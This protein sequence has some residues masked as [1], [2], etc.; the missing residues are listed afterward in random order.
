MGK[1]EGAKWLP[2]KP[3]RG[4]IA[5]NIGDL[6]SHWSDGELYANLHRVRMPRDEEE[7]YKS[8]Y[9]IAYFIQP[10]SSYVIEPK[11]NDPATAGEFMEMWLKASFK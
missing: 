7:C 5:V 4:G 2:V 10:D 6:L 8:R 3:V 1:N 11:N 9:S